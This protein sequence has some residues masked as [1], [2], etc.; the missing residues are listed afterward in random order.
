MAPNRIARCISEWAIAWPTRRKCP[1][2]SAARNS[3]QFAKNPFA[4]INPACPL[5]D[6]REAKR[7]AQRSGEFLTAFACTSGTAANCRR[8]EGALHAGV[9]EVADAVSRNQFAAYKEYLQA[10]LQR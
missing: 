3:K 6:F 4:A 10:T 2:G 5:D 8:E 1:Y 7:V 9:Y